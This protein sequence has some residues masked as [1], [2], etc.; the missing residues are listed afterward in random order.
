MQPTVNTR[1]NPN[2][3][4]VWRFYFLGAIALGIEVLILL[5]RVPSAAEIFSFLRLS[6]VRL[7]MAL[8]VSMVMLLCGWF[9][10]ERMKP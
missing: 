9:L 3:L 10:C 4:L 2:A 1:D 5:V 6:S 7:A 8:G